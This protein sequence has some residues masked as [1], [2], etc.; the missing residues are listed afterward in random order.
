MIWM[1]KPIASRVHRIISLGKVRSFLPLASGLVQRLFRGHASKA[2]LPGRQ[3]SEA[4][5]GCLGELGPQPLALVVQLPALGVA[6]HQ[7]R[8]HGQVQARYMRRI[9]AGGRYREVDTAERQL[10]DV[11][12]VVAQLAAAE[13]VDLVA[14]LSQFL[15]LLREDLRRG[16][17][18]AALLVGVA[19]L[20]HGLGRCGQG[21]RQRNGGEQCQA[22]HDWVSFVSWGSKPAIAMRRPAWWDR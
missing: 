11:L 9:A 3:E 21:H 6:V 2:G 7:E 4:L 22:V 16:L 17:P 18:C 13:D 15:D 10:L 19:E 12:R 8:H 1:L 20:E 5:F 14:A